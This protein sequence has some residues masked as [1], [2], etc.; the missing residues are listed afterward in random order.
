M[1]LAEI[2][3][4]GQILRRFAR[5]IA[6]FELVL[7]AACSSTGPLEPLDTSAPGWV[8]RQGQALWRPEGD[9]PEIAGDV[10]LATHPSGRSYIQFSKT[11]PILSGRLS[12]IGWE[13][14]A[15]AE[16]KHYSGRGAPPKKIAWLQV[17]R[18][19]EGREISDRWTVAHPSKDFIALENQFTGERLQVQLQP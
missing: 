8:V 4:S 17:L 9:K 15:T 14:E 13:F 6:T 7:F 5:W 19:H 1:P 10:I 18:V 11:L 16:N 12:P 3:I 2:N